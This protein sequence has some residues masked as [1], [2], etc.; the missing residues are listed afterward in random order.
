MSKNG[1]LYEILL[2]AFWKLFYRVQ[3]KQFC[4]NIWKL[5]YNTV[6]I[7]G[8]YFCKLCYIYKNIYWYYITFTFEINFWMTIIRENNVKHNFRCTEMIWVCFL[9]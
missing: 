7:L 2:R 3:I 5:K 9:I 4:K 1:S 6:L 8:K